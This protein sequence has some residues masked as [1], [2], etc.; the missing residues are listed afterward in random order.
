MTLP[1]TLDRALTEAARD[2]IARMEQIG[3]A[4]HD[5]YVTAYAGTGV[6]NVKAQDRNLM[7]ADRDAL[8][9]A[10]ADAGYEVV[11]WWIP[12]QGV[13][14]LSDGVRAGVSFEVRKGQP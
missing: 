8:A 3:Y 4:H 7:Q 6:V 9:D 11:R 5:L 10:L 2:G 13:S 1:E 14:W 12:R